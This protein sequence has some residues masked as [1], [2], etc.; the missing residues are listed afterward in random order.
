LTSLNSLLSAGG[1]FV[2]AYKAAGFQS[3]L[4]GFMPYG[5][6]FYDG[7]AN[8]LTRRFSNGLQFI[9]AYTWSHNIDDSTA[10][11]FSTYTTPRRPQDFQNVRGDTSDSALDHRQRFSYQVLYDVPFLKHDSNWFK[12]NILG[13]WEIAPIYQ[14]QIGTWVTV[15]S[16]VDSNMNGD[17]AGD[18]TI[19]NPSGNNSVGSGTTALTNSAGATV[20]YLANNSNAGYVWRPRAPSPPAAAT[21]CV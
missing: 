19:V 4:V 21:P 8:Q 18:R 1:N 3:N 10:D 20:A 5:R 2:P 6:S 16:G 13:S 17:S 15:Q 11:V 7:W 12:R 9:A 14:Y